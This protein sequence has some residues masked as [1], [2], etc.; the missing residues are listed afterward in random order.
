MRSLVTLEHSDP[1]ARVLVLTN[2]W[3]NDDRADYGVFVKRQVDSLIAAGL[4]CDV[5]FVRGYR[6]PLAYLVA[7]V[8]LFAWNLHPRHQYALVH[9]HGG[10]VAMPARFYVRAPVLVSYCGDDLLGTPQADGTVS[11]GRR[12]RR[13]VIR[14]H[15]LL[16]GATLTKSEEMERALPDRVARRNA[17]VPNGVDMDLFEA[18]DRGA[19]RRRLGWRLDERVILFAANPAVER[20]RYWL[21]EAATDWAAKRVGP[22]RLHVANGVEPTRMPELMSAADCLLLT[23]SIEGSP[24]VVKEALMCDLP[25]VSTPVGDVSE[26][27]ADVEP[28]WV[29]PAD[30][31]AL[32]DA[33]TECLVEPRRSNGRSVSSWL[34]AEEIAERVLGL[35]ESLAPTAVADARRRIPSAA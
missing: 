7:A 35:Y 16:L 2:M 28:S 25:I 32:G 13:A 23:S 12:V 19:A 27:L 10:E 34:G 14:A 31:Q 20:K 3:P 18:V 8:T 26:L 4:R 17:V 11:L 6:S 15:S 1:E 9:G 24:N 29:R 30:P 21:A 22:I 5:L 33:L